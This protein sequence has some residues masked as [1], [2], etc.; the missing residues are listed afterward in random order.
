M[1][2]F[3]RR[4]SQ[5]GALSAGFYEERLYEEGIILKREFMK[6]EFGKPIIIRVD[7]ILS[8]QELP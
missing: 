3:L 4:S 7:K 8:D 5:F 6:E 2:D 1:N